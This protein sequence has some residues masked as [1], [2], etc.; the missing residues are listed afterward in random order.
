MFAMP[1]NENTLLRK[2]SSES[3]VMT[4]SSTKRGVFIFA[5]VGRVVRNAFCTVL[6]PYSYY[7]VHVNVE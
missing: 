1:C 5:L 6:I 4:W 7:F 3:G 2:L